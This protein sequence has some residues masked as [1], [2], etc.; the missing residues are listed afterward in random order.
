[1]STGGFN[2]AWGSSEG[3]SSSMFRSPVAASGNSGSSSRSPV[4]AALCNLS[5]TPWSLS[6]S[7][8]GAAAALLVRPHGKLRAQVVSAEML[9]LD[10]N[11]K[12]CIVYKV[13]VADDRGEWTVT[14]RWVCTHRIA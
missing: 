13:R 6:S 12:D 7:Q 9:S 5:R 10:G 4:V 14:R 8:A 3:G 11:G 1:M 2:A